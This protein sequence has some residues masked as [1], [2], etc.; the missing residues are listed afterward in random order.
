MIDT[1]G[2][3]LYINVPSFTEAPYM[4]K[5]NGT[6]YLT[7]AYGWPESIVYATSDNPLGPFSRPETLNETLPSETNHQSLVQFKGTWYFIYHNAAL[8]GGSPHHRSV[9]ADLLHFDDDGSIREIVQTKGGVL[10]TGPGPIGDNTD[11]RIICRLSGKALTPSGAGDGAALVQQTETGAESEKW[12][13]RRVGSGTYQILNAES[14][15][16]VNVENGS[17]EGLAK[18]QQATCVEEARQYFRLVGTGDGYFAV[19]NH[20]SGRVL[21]VLDLSTAD[22]AAIIQWDYLYAENQQWEIVE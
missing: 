14:G 16:C 17:T 13:F 15:L 3:I 21:D 8:L 10:Q 4:N 19:V 11:Y 2:E 1:E 12:R 7:Y 6:Y 18:L 9:T 5:V 20:A 22:G